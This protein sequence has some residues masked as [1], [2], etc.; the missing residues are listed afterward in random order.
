M[1]VTYKSVLSCINFNINDDDP[2]NCVKME[3][4]FQLKYEK[5]NQAL[6]TVSFL[7]GIH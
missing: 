1:N 4:I 3:I 2:L 5:R 6:A 7:C